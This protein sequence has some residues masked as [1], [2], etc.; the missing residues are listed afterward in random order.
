[1]TPNFD[2]FVNNEPI[3]VD[4]QGRAHTAEG[5]ACSY[6]CRTV[7]DDDVKV[8]LDL[9]RAFENP[10]AQ[11]RE[12]LQNIDNGCPHIHHLKPR[13]MDDGLAWTKISKLGHPLPCSSGMCN[14]K[15]RVLRTASM[16]YPALQKLLHSVYMGRKCHSTVAMVD[17]GL[18]TLDCKLICN[19]VQVNEYE[20]LIG[21]TVVEQESD[22]PSSE[23]V[24][25]SAEGLVGIERNIQIKYA[26]IFEAYRKKLYESPVCPCSSCERLHIRGNVTQYT[27]ETEKFSSDRWRQLKQYLAEK[28]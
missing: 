2:Q 28:G 16:H 24:E 21:E 9:K 11:I 8:I 15:L 14:S 3:P 10:I 12:G 23:N 13:A 20:N 18:F 4:A 7:S 1:M 5:S 26:S 6:A 25:F 22:L 27:A 17:I 19:L